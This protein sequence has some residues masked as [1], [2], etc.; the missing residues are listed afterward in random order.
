MGRQRRDEATTFAVD[1]GIASWQVE[2]DGRVL[3]IDGRPSSPFHDDPTVLSFPYL[4][5][6]AAATSSWSAATSRPDFKAVHIGGAAC[7]LPRALSA[8]HAK[9]THVVAEP[10]AKLAHWARN[11]ADLPPSKKLRIKQKDGLALLA[12]M[13]GT[14]ADVVVRDAFLGGESVPHLDGQEFYDSCMQVLAPDGL[15]LVNVGAKA[16]ARLVRQA[17]DQMSLLGATLLAGDAG[18]LDDRSEGNVVLVT[19][20]STTHKS[21]LVSALRQAI[22]AAVPGVIVRS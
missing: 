8:L 20:L 7:A 11:N 14:S 17:R 18:A 13:P 3:Y 9:S 21:P 15:L 12:S 1:S 10:D 2:G 19:A 4:C 16:G 6:M 22:S 5:I